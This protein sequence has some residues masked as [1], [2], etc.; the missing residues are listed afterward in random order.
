MR[1]KHLGRWGRAVAVALG[2]G[3]AAGGAAA[4]PAP[5][6]PAEQPLSASLTG[7]AKAEHGAGSALFK[8][9]DYA[10]ALARFERAYELS[11]EPRVLWNVAACQKNLRRYAKMLATLRRIEAESGDALSP[12]DRKDIAE[13]VQAAGAFVSRLEITASEPGATVFVDDE[14]VGTT[15]L[16]APVPLDIGERRVRV[17]KPGFVDF[18]RRERVV[19]GGSVALVARLER[20]VHRGRLAI[21]AGPDDLIA[22]DGKV[23]GK[24]RWEGPVPSGTRALRVT[25]PGK[26]P[27]EAQVLVRDDERRR[28]DVTLERA[29]ERGGADRWLWIGGGAAI[30]AGAIVA[31]ALLSEPGR[32]AE[33][34]SLGTVPLGFGGR[35]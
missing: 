31:G 27:H 30:F 28:I 19:G 34:G 25:G 22:V 24:G 5:A 7:M 13:L 14:P 35:R 29:P 11:R 4:Q 18:V 15:P 33:Q 9:G 3:L 8:E 1:G 23:V 12:R 32:P 26:T 2:V 21:T 6:A 17:S 16:A 20:A 10:G